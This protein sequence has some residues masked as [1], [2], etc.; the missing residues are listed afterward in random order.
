ML[1]GSVLALE[2]TSILSE[3]INFLNKE[4]AWAMN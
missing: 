4:K 3:V 2:N 1:F